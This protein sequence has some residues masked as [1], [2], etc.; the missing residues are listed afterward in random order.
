MGS[1]PTDDPTGARIVSTG[2]A[3]PPFSI[4]QLDS[5]L[6]AQELCI[7]QRWKNALPALYRKSGV[8]KRGSVLLQSDSETITERQSFYTVA[9]DASPRGPTTGQRMAV[10][11]QHA[12][13]LLER[14]CRAC[15][16]RVAWDASCMPHLVSVSCT[17]FFSPGVDHELMDSLGL[18]NRVQRTHVG[19]MGCHG[20]VN[21][22]RIAQ[23]IA[24][25]DPKANVLVGFWTRFAC[26]SDPLAS[27]INQ[28]SR[29]DSRPRHG[30]RS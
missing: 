24:I 2:T 23:A 28:P 10:Y 5:A 7:T 11:A 18:S 13:P 22:L 30:T 19:F 29:K 27:T 3:F 20:L 17:G 1:K 21:G 9:T 26:G 16:D 14:A 15:L 25:A 6:L 4:T 12:G 8:T